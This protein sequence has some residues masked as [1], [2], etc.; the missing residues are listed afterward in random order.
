M[1]YFEAFCWTMGSVLFCGFVLVAILHIW[2]ARIMAR[3]SGAR[4]TR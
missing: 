2:K 4:T 3:R 1:T